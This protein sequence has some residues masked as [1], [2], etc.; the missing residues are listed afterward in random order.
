M[1]CHSFNTTPEGIS[2]P[3]VE[4]GF[5]GKN[6]EQFNSVV[7]AIANKLASNGK[8]WVFVFDQVNKLFSREGKSSIGELPFPY[9]MISF[10]RKPGCVISILSA[11]ANN[12]ISDNHESFIEYPHPIEM[13]AN[14]LLTVF[15]NR[16]TETNVQ[17]FTG[18]HPYYVGLYLQI[19][20]VA[21]LEMVHTDIFQSALKLQQT[22]PLKW[23]EMLGAIILCV[24]GCSRPHAFPYDKKS[25]CRKGAAPKESISFPFSHLY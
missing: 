8:Y 7:N 2:A 14:E 13:T 19:G 21:F 24:L 17:E 1:I 20:E 5:S 6:L 16:Y 25:C 9:D 12:E 22:E 4:S 11:S 15:D 10:I 23:R 3:D 18:G